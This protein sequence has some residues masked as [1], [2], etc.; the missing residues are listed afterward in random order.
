MGAV[1]KAKPSTARTKT[2]PRQMREIESP[3]LTSREA[4]AYLRIPSLGALYGHIRQ[5]RLPVCR[6]GGGLRFDTRDLD[7]WVHGYGSVVEWNR[8]TRKDG[9][10]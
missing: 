1:S 2:K 9:E 5:N 4:L 3:Y 7:A 10:R 6:V 8:A